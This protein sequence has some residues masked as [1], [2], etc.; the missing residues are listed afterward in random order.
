MSTVTILQ[1]PPASRPITTAPSIPFQSTCQQCGADVSYA[2]ASAAAE[3]AQRRI[4]EL[5]AQVRILTGKAT[6]AVD[7]LAD[8]EDQLHQLKSTASA[9]G[10]KER[11]S[12]HLAPAHPLSRSTSAEPSSKPLH[13]T[14]GTSADST[15]NNNKS[16]LPSRLQNLL[17][18]PS[19]PATQNTF[20]ASARNP[21][22]IPPTPNIAPTDSP[23]NLR[24]L[25]HNESQIRASLEQQL[26]HNQSEL[27]E[28]SSQ[29]FTEANEMV[30]QERKAR[31]KLEDRVEVLERRDREKAE[32]LE[33]LR[34]RVGRVER[35]RGLL[36]EK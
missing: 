10:A 5:E 26:N 35:V 19:A 30:A 7:K 4:S 28:L 23:E 1:P 29:L 17:R 18:P 16:R 32:R 12:P 22:P 27:E 36:G 6:A 24:V 14:N 8:Y 34:K 15:S 2:A 13:T 9:G 33:E 21:P 11:S 31:K 25:L 20:P 3:D